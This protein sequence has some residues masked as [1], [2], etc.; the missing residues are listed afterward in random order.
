MLSIKAGMLPVVSPYLGVGLGINVQFEGTQK[1]EPNG[2]AVETPIG[3]TNTNAFFILGLGAEFKLTKFRI[4]P[5]FTANINSGADD[6]AT[7]NRAESN[8]DLH[9]SIGFYYGS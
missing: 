3:G 9:L 7:P 2:V 4:I 1:W 6:P 5:E 8:T